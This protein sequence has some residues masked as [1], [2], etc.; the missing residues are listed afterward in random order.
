MLSKSETTA[1]QCAGVDFYKFPLRRESLRAKVLSLNYG[2]NFIQK[3]QTNF[4]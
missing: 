4:Q 2:Q 3:A 1:L